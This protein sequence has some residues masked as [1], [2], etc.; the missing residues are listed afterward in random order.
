MDCCHSEPDRFAGVLSHDATQVQ[1]TF[2]R[3]H[4][5]FEAFLQFRR[6]TVHEDT[7]KAP[8]DSIFWKNNDWTWEIPIGMS[9]CQFRD[10]PLP[11]KA[12]VRGFVRCFVSSLIYELKMK[13][14]RDCERQRKA[15]M[16]CRIAWW[17][18]MMTTTLLA[19]FDCNPVHV[20]ESD[21]M[22]G[23][24]RTEPNKFL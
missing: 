3:C 13:L 9:E 10:I 15:L 2:R 24:V 5:F 12:E 17:H 22:D 19:D 14:L 4:E 20:S 6:R 11:S 21:A 1:G 8:L 18:R 16:L 23:G 7:A